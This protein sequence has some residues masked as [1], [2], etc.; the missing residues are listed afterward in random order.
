MKVGFFGTPP[1]VL[2]YLKS[3]LSSHHSLEF[4]VTGI[5]KPKGRGMK[6]TSPE[7][8]VFAVNNGIP[9][10]QPESLRDVDFLKKIK[11]FNV[12]IFIVIAY[13]KKLSSEILNL[14]KFGCINVHF[15][16]LPRWRGA[17]PVNWAI[18]SGDKETGVTIMKMDEGLDTGDIIK[19]EKIYIDE[20]KTSIDV[21][22]EL[23]PLGIKLLLDTL[24]D[25][26]NGR[27]TFTK[28]DDSK[29]TYART[30][31]KSDGKIDWTKDALSIHNL[32]RGLQPWPGAFTYVNGKLLKIWKSNLLDLDSLPGRVDKIGKQS[33]I[34]GTGKGSLEI[35][36]TQEEGRNRSHPSDFFKRNN[37]KE[38]DII[39]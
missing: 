18:I 13:G 2:E 14:P 10:F 22:E 16:L 35:V 27:A 9:F 3:I 29:A 30:F 28:Q 33:V 12:D 38:G 19:Q 4:I 36:L 1:F 11:S 39:F 24:I 23:I 25:L 32:I 26:E 34:I 21:F 15:S 7:P 8:K 31:I 17:A 20:N 5:D 6:I 37:I